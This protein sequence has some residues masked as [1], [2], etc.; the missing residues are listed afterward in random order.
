MSAPRSGWRFAALGLLPV[1]AL[2]FRFSAGGPLRVETEGMEPTIWRGE[3]VWMAPVEVDAL[4]VGDL[5]VAELPGEGLIV[6][7]LVGLEG[8]EVEVHPSRGLFLNGEQR[9]ED[10]GLLALR[11]SGDC[12]MEAQP[13]ARERWS[14]AAVAVRSGGPADRRRVPLGHAYLLGDDRAS[15]GDSRLW[16]PVPVEQIV[17]L[18][19]LRLLSG[20]PC[21]IF[22]RWERSFARL[23]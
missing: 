19:R 9:T 3:L 2:V 21:E 5:V 22:P 6:K 15:S 16:G 4:Q 12:A 13:H 7:R 1:A 8:D 11:P 18:V 14:G 17:G 20:S 10:A 23:R